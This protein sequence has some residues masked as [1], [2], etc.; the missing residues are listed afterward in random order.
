[1]AI[2]PEEIRRQ[3]LYAQTLQCTPAG[4]YAILNAVCMIS[5]QHRNDEQLRTK[6]QSLLSILQVTADSEPK[7]QPESV[8]SLA[9]R[10]RVK[11][12]REAI[13]DETSTNE[14][15]TA[16]ANACDEL[17][18][19]NLTPL[20]C[21]LA[22]V[23][24]RDFK[25]IDPIKYSKQIADIMEQYIGESPFN[26]LES[27]DR[28]LKETLGLLKHTDNEYPELYDVITSFRQH[29]KSPN[30]FALVAWD[31]AAVKL[32]NAVMR[33]RDPSVLATINAS[34]QR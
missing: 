3:E 23:A 33:Q 20:D 11:L 14:I 15:L 32:Y 10:Q 24:L 19:G 18:P 29:I 31:G 4:L 5:I 12:L 22:A 13:T 25:S 16:L 8:S 26:W 2:T 9:F 34:I 7:A 27:N 30:V 6:L 28:D 1:M 21:G 17:P